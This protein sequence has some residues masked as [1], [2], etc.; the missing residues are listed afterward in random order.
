MH[1]KT[2]ANFFK[3]WE[4]TKGNH[5]KINCYLNYSKCSIQFQRHDIQ[6]DIYMNTFPVKSKSFLSSQWISSSSQP[7]LPFCLFWFAF[8]T[9]IGWIFTINQSALRKPDYTTV[10]SVNSVISFSCYGLI[11]IISI[12]NSL[13]LFNANS[14][15]LKCNI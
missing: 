2:W 12:Y 13:Q 10:Y 4:K 15:L 1:L 8:W 14:K 11:V 6:F 7:G 9:L 3:S 5:A